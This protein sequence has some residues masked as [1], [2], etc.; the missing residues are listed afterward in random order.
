MMTQE[1]K[2]RVTQCVIESACLFPLFSYLHIFSVGGLP[3]LVFLFQIIGG[4]TAFGAFLFLLNKHLPVRTFLFWML[5]S[6][7]PLAIVFCT[8]FHNPSLVDLFLLIFLLI[9]LFFPAFHI[10]C[11]TRKRKS[12]FRNILLCIYVFSL[13]LG[14]VI[15]LLKLCYFEFLPVAALA[16]MIL[17]ISSAR[18]KKP[19]L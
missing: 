2:I 14:C 19:S 7:S 18:E 6:I 15:W 16:G 3:V 5:M 1:K 10:I 8:F 13:V 4:I 17:A 11:E 9:Q 12:I